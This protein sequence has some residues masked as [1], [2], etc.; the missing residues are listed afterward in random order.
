MLF[1]AYNSS[2]KLLHIER[3]PNSLRLLRQRGCFS[4]APPPCSVEKR[5]Q[6]MEELIGSGN[7]MEKQVRFKNFLLFCAENEEGQS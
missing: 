2:F 4:P 3:E 6:T 1:L 5:K 7:I